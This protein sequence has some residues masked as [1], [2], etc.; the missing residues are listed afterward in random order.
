MFEKEF[1]L[2]KNP[3]ASL[4]RDVRRLL[5]KRRYEVDE[6]GFIHFRNRVNIK[7]GGFFTSSVLRHEAV[8][9]ALDAGD[10][11]ALKAAQAMVSRFSDEGCFRMMESYDHN[12][13]P[14]AGIDFF[15][16]LLLGDGSKVSAWY[17]GPFCSSWTS[18]DDA[19]SNW[20]GGSTLVT[21]GVKA[22]ELQASEYDE[23]NGGSRPLANFAN[24]PSGQT[25]SA[26]TPTRIT[27]SSG[28]S[29][30]NLHG[31]TLNSINQINYNQ[32]TQTVIAA[33]AFM[34]GETPAPKQNLTGGDKIDLDYE[35]SGQ[36]T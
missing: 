27:L 13:V 17:H 12:Q 16:D 3:I 32:T 20:A 15:L 7:A 24:P 4:I 9:R 23:G 6:N 1:S 34:D 5:E 29:A 14:D 10:E 26:S 2:T 21:P 35:M 19:L 31:S 36:S 33:A 25:I 8:Q 28:I 11:L 18:F 22:R 30:L